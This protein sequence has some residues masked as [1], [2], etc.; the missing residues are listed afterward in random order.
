MLL[1]PG[2][3]YTFW[4]HVTL[5]ARASGSGCLLME[6]NGP[7]RIVGWDGGDNIS[8]FALHLDSA[9]LVLSGVRAPA[10]TLTDQQA[11]TPSWAVKNTALFTAEERLVFDDAID[12]SPKATIGDGDDLSL[13]R[14]APAGGQGFVLKP[15]D[16]FEGSASVALPSPAGWRVDLFFQAD[17]GRSRQTPM[18]R[19]TALFNLLRSLLSSLLL[20]PPL[21]QLDWWGNDAQASVLALQMFNQLGAGW[22]PLYGPLFAHALDSLAHQ[23]L[24]LSQALTDLNDQI[25]VSPSFTAGTRYAS[26]VAPVALPLPLLGAAAGSDWSRR[27]RQ[28]TRVVASFP[29]GIPPTLSIAPHR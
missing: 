5:S 2:E 15:G 9:N 11:I 23:V 4:Q 20:P 13:A 21:G 22:D 6:I 25:E 16:A 27:S 3:A 29:R 1:N 26:A 19:M 28:R 18:H 14:A 12:I 7:D 10:G 8:S 17:A 24:D